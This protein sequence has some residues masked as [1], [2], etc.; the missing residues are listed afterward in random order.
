MHLKSNKEIFWGFIAGFF[1]FWFIA[2]SVCYLL[3]DKLF[4]DFQLGNWINSLG[5]VIGFIFCVLMILLIRKNLK[6]HH[7]E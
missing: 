3:R 1:V 7:S 5:A 4:K 2:F 6:S